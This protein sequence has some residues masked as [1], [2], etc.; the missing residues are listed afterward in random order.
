MKAEILELR[1]TQMS[2]GFHQVSKKE[3][4]LRHMTGLKLKEYLKSKKVPVVIGPRGKY[5][6]IDHHHLCKA[7]YNL[8]QEEVYIDVI[9]DCSDM[10]VPDF[11]ALMM[12][13]K[14]VWLFDHNGKKIDIDDLP[15]NIRH[16]K[17]DPYRSLAGII[18]RMGA[19]EKV[20]APFAEFHWANFLRTKIRHLESNID[21]EAIEA[22][23]L[24]AQSNAA[25]G[26]PGFIRNGASA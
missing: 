18:R 17:D 26:L 15:K 23:M 2:I 8:D 5:Y 7:V 9:M 3:K 19:Y 14:Y 6:I 12:E 10:P 16:L 13:R 20:A 4:K 1:P 24:A 25:H 22:A 21:E 11:W